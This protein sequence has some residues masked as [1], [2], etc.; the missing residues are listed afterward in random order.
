MSSCITSPSLSDIEDSPATERLRLYIGW[1]AIRALVFGAFKMD[2]CTFWRI[3]YLFLLKSTD[4]L[5]IVKG[6]P[7]LLTPLQFWGCK[8]TGAIPVFFNSVFQIFMFFCLFLSQTVEEPIS[9]AGLGWV[10]LHNTSIAWCFSERDYP[11]RGI[12]P[13]K[14]VYLREKAFFTNI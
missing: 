8:T 11:L 13:E 14:A 3:F 12:M 7:A 10:S 9:S 2:F 6:W 5:C 1:T 4:F